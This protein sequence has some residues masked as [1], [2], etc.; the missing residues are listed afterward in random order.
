M[1]AETGACMCGF[2][3]FGAIGTAEP[4]EWFEFVPWLENGCALSVEENDRLQRGYVSVIHVPDNKVKFVL[5]MKRIFALTIPTATLLKGLNKLPY[6]LAQE[7]SRFKAE[8]LIN[9]TSF[10]ELY[11]FFSK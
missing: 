10:P 11:R 4:D 8:K 9:K 1:K 6:V 5:E 2:L 7:I 3:D